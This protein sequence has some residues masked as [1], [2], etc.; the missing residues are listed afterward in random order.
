MTY[1]STHRGMCR[2]LKMVLFALLNLIIF[3]TQIEFRERDLGG[4]IFH[5]C[6]CLRWN[7]IFELSSRFF[8]W[9]NFGGEGEPEEDVFIADPSL[10]V[11]F[12]YTSIGCL[13]QFP[14][15]DRGF[16]FFFNPRRRT[17]KFRRTAS[18]STI[19]NIS[20]MLFGEILLLFNY[21]HTRVDWSTIY[22][23]SAAAKWRNYIPFN[24]QPTNQPGLHFNHG[25]RQCHSVSRTCRIYYESTHLLLLLGS[26]ALYNVFFNSFDYQ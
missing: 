3:C 7:F 22:Y 4:N 6:R 11:A 10:V 21:W 16:L 8:D 18:L 2:R 14:W 25:E 17:S 12:A 19:I 24:C 5:I 23:Y 26:G 20:C 9:T 15:T 13:L 1:N